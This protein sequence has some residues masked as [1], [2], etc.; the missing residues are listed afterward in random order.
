M[1]PLAAL[2]LAQL[3]SPG[4]PACPFQDPRIRAELLDEIDRVAARLAGEQVVT[5]EG[6]ALHELL[7][8]H[9]RGHGREPWA[10]WIER[11][12]ASAPVDA[13]CPP[14]VL[15][16][17]TGLLEVALASER[18]DYAQSVCLEPLVRGGRAVDVHG[19]L[20]AALA[21]VDPGEP[22]PD[23]WEPAPAERWRRMRV[24]GLRLETAHVERLLGHLESALERYE[25]WAPRLDCGDA[26]RALG[27]LRARYQLACL[28]RLGRTGELRELCR[29]EVRLGDWKRLV[30]LVESYRPPSRRW[31]PAAR[32]L[33]SSDLEATIALAE[34][35]HRHADGACPWAEEAEEAEEAERARALLRWPPPQEGGGRQSRERPDAIISR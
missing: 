25:S 5:T 34:R 22:W 12:D 24:E 7:D 31:T 21:R 19:L 30:D 13:T 4:V 33:A 11:H 18:G 16:Q 29:S 3:P 15:A 6:R 27:H 1:L 17:L 14:D 26:G 2:L 8:E 10:E 32:A 23:A 28:A 9:R 20:V 35:G